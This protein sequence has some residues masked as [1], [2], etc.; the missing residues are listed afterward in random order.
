MR[1]KRGVLKKSKK[2]RYL[3]AAKGYRGAKSRRVSLA[4]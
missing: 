4:K 1:I 2:K 3:K